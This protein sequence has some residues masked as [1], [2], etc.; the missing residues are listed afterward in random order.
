MKKTILPIAAFSFLIMTAGTTNAQIFKKLKD[1]VSSKIEN[2]VDN[3]VDNVLDGSKTTTDSAEKSVSR[4]TNSKIGQLS[5]ADYSFTAGSQLLYDDNFI[6]DSVGDMA[7]NWKSSGGGSIAT[8]ANEPGRWL[9]LKEFTTY[10]LKRSESLPENFTV[11]FEILTESKDNAKD[12]N[13]LSFGF[14][15]DNTISSYIGDA[16]NENAITGTQIHYWNKEII[17]SSSDTKIYNTIKFP[18]AEYAV[19]KMKVAITVKNKHMQVFLDKVKV[20]DTDM[21]GRDEEKKFFYISTDTKLDN[22]AR[23]GVGNFKIA[24][25]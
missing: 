16:Y 18:L 13:S 2:K 17:N 9:F 1:K 25:L 15:H 6:Q 7:H 8:A 23:I 11:E 5:T 19:A 21:F 20:L 3:A 22:E 10:K 12:L 24:A 4:G 14:A